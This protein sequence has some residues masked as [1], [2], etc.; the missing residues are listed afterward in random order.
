MTQPSL[1]PR[2]LQAAEVAFWLVL[3]SGLLLLP[4]HLTLL[5]QILVFGLFAVSLDIALGYAGILTV[6][7]AAFFGAG[8]YTAGLLAKHGWGEPFSGL[9]LAALVS[10]ALGYLLSA[11]VVRGA[12]LT[13]LMI[14][15]GVCLL[16]TELVN[17]LTGITGGSDGLQG[18]DVWPVLGLFEFDLFGKTAFVYSLV[19][20]LAAFLLVRL[21]LRSP[22]GLALRGIHDSR[23]RM[24]AIGCPVD[25]RLRLA[26]AF[27]AAVAGYSGALLAQT[28]QFVGIES[29]GFNR[30]AEILIILVLGGTGRL[31]GGLIG[32]IVYMFVL[33]LI[34][35]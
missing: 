5:G 22:F 24:L 26:Y 35:I 20:V 25:A 9:L 30:S 8:A 34:H 2:T 19:M 32:A 4:D 3:A 17:R 29:I 10:L 1:S 21:V 16:L 14:T 23:K 13:R 11:F 18:M 7:H 12:N 33:S 6:G 15:I 31:Y 27:S 28:T